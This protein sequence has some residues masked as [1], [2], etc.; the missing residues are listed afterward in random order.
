[1]NIQSGKVRNMS[2]R[3]ARHGASAIGS[4]LAVF[5]HTAVFLVCLGVLANGYIYL[6]QK[7]AE[8]GRAIRQ[9]KQD[10][11]NIEREIDNL[12]IQRAALSSW[13]N[14]STS[15]RRFNL[16]LKPAEARQVRRLII[17][18]PGDAV[19]YRT[20]NLPDSTPNTAA[21]AQKRSGTTRMLVS[22]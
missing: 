7:I 8:T 11:H 1:M 10:L 17:Y 5:F 13:S 18:A 19:R 3:A 4:R 9:T 12:V 15:I 2:S 20:A 6:N 16:P 14:I 21:T 22:R